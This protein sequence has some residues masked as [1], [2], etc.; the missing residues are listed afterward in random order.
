VIQGP[1]FYAAI[2]A[3]FVGPLGYGLGVTA[4]KSEAYHKVGLVETNLSQACIVE[5]DLLWKDEI[6]IQNEIDAAHQQ[7]D[8][9][10]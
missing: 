7:D 10:W 5:L 9:R 8:D 3:A 1:I 2:T 4:G 6:K